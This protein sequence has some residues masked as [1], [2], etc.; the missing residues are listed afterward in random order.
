MAKQTYFWIRL[1]AAWK[2]VSTEST[3]L[4]ASLLAIL[5]IIAAGLF[6]P[7]GL[8][9]FEDAGSAADWFAAVGTWVIGFG[10]M[11]LAAGDRE[12]KLHERREKRLREAKAEHTRLREIAS[13]LVPMQLQLMTVTRKLRSAEDRDAN[14]AHPML[15]HLANHIVEM[16]WGAEQEGVV[17]DA[18]AN[19]VSKVRYVLRRLNDVIALYDNSL[20]Q[21]LSDTREKE[22]GRL[23]DEVLTY[24]DLAYGVLVEMQN[25]LNDDAKRS[26]ALIDTLGARIAR[27]DR[28]LTD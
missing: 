9:V 5:G 20:R 28:K 15:K 19:V 8:S 26:N 18:T 6:S 1:C 10:A 14:R 23:L 2:S 7:F 16:K 4:L 24:V 21:E 11:R 3:I 12:L 17:S 27:D 13:W 25:A 22:S